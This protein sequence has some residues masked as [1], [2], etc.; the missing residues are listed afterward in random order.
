MLAMPAERVRR[1]LAEI[2]NPHAPLLKP[3]R[4]RLVC[5]GLRKEAE[6]QR[7]RRGKASE[8]ARKRWDN[9]PDADAMPEQCERI[10]DA[11]FEQ[12]TPSPTPTPS[13]IPS[14]AAADKNNCATPAPKRAAVSRGVV[15]S[16]EFLQFWEEYPR[17]KGKMD[18][19][20]AFKAA[21]G[22][23]PIDQLVAE[24]RL[25][26]GCIEWNKDGGQFIPY[27]ATWL[28]RGGWDDEVLMPFES[29]EGGE[30]C[31]Q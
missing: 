12:C 7:D 24:V 30:S 2:Q 20:R 29:A 17:K 4:D 13:P 11:S 26:T 10:P 6:K 28:R 31:Q 1:D 16:A 3:G 21:K 18:A 5:N 25:Q 8:A 14:P 27:P 15:Y 23:P 9:V 22:K 19:F